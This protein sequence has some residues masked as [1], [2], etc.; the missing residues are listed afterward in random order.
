[1][2]KWAAFRP[3]YL[4]QAPQ[5]GSTMKMIAIQSYG[6]INLSID[7]LEKLPS[8]YHRVEMV[9]Q[10]I[11]LHDDVAV[12]WIPDSSGT[13]SV[14]CSTNRHYLPVDERNL[15]TKAAKLMAERF[16]NNRQGMIR[17]DIKK[18][19]PVAAGLAGGSSNGAAVLHAV[20]QLWKLDLSVQELC[21]IGQELGADVPFCLMGQAAHD[22]RLKGRFEKDALAAGCALATGIGTELKP[23]KSMKVFVVLSKP[24]IGVSTREVY[25]GLRQDEIL[26]RPDTKQLI[27]GLA[28]QNWELVEKNMLNVLEFYTL[29]MYDMV[30]YTKNKMKELCPNA[31]VLMSGSGPTVFGIYKTEADAQKVYEGMKKIN[32]ETFLTET[33]P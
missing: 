3:F 27:T 30:V 7:V 1:M 17:V 24:A 20:N 33:T 32:R 19:L 18:R 28:D 6:K 13:I 26:K 22:P 21:D 4:E 31:T 8:G 10:Q 23:L 29:K 2:T 9:M 25:Q 16:A 15:A 11:D 12:K 5:R 14:V